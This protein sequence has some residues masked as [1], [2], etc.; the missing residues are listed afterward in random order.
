M[1]EYKPVDASQTIINY[2]DEPTKPPPTLEVGVPAWLRQNLF[3]SPA[4]IVVTILAALLVLVLV[5]GFYDWAVRSANWFTII[6]NQRLF[7]MD[8]F[9]RAFEWRAALIVLIAALLTG[10]SFAAW[11][12]RSMRVLTVMALATLTVVIVVPPV[13]NATVSQPKSYLTAGNVDIIDRASELTPQP[14]LAFIAQAG[15]TVTLAL[16]TDEVAD[17]DTLSNL[18]GFSDR[19]ANALANAARNRLDRQVDTGESFDRMISRELTEPSEE[20]MREAIRT[21]TRTNDMEA[22]TSDYLRHVGE[23]LSAAGASIGELKVWLNRLRN[24][25]RALDERDEAILEAIGA[26]QAAAA[27]LTSEDAMTDALRAAVN[28]LT[29]TALVSEQ[30]EDLGEL[31]ILHLSEDL[32]GE[33]D[34]S[35][36]DEELIEPTQWEENFLRDL[37]VRLLT[38]QSV[39]AVYDLGKTPMQVAVRD[40]MTLDILAEGIL[41]PA[42][43][44]ITYEI[45]SD[46]WYVL[47]K[48]AAE[49]EEGST[50]L[51]VGGLYPIVERTLSANE[52]QFVRVTDNELEIFGVRPQLDSRPVPMLALIDNQFRGLRDLQV[53]LVHFIP[54]FF[55][56]VVALL[57]P[58]LITVAWGVALGR[59]LAHLKGENTNFTSNRGRGV[60]LA[61]AFSP[62]LI[63]LAYFALLD[64]PNAM[65]RFA[66]ARAKT[67]GR[68]WCCCA[69]TTDG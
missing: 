19:A 58:F 18:A 31:L 1:S 63:L 21:F 56:Q 47:S 42:G 57:L 9:E 25:T 29:E 40:A 67:G 7:M 68:F 33:R 22:A 36:D 61:W 48:T 66:R 45:P 5:F 46:G 28:A 41:T 26:T 15:E 65:N 4:D 20:R 24:A 54:L 55:E 37:F 64:G 59:A 53:Y 69:G 39:V 3:G 51:S 10:V 27:N 23:R 14:N 38:P 52:S 35:D 11:A 17:I 44:Q 32:I 13:I 16:A 50:L 6:N 12:R 34:Q 8:R 30:L 43:E 60:V 62:L 49:G 2:E